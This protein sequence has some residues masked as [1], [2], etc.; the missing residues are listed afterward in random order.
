MSAMRSTLA[1]KMGVKNVSFTGRSKAGKRV[2][3]IQISYQH[4]QPNSVGEFPELC[5]WV[6]IDQLNN[7]EMELFENAAHDKKRIQ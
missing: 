2:T 5:S 6:P 4:I 3:L 1:E 7:E